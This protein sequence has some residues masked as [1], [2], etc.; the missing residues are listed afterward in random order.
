M[1]PNSVRFNCDERTDCIL[2]WINGSKENGVWNFCGVPDASIV[3]GRDWY[4][5]MIT[6]NDYG[7]AEDVTGVFEY[8]QFA[9]CILFCSNPKKLN[10]NNVPLE[11]DQHRKTSLE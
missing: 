10:T 4:N 6:P 7:S 2:N 5:L 3:S 1:S 8:K 11:I 9:N